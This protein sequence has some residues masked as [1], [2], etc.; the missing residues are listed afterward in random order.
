[1]I[2]CQETDSPTNR[3]TIYNPSHSQVV[4]ETPRWFHL[5]PRVPPP[6]GAQAL[7]YQTPIV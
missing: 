5:T 1:M 4:G 2:A 7:V 6:G 3:Y